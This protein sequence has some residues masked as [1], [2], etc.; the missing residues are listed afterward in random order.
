MSMRRRWRESSRARSSTN[1]AA[2]AP[3]TPI[4]N[5]ICAA[6]ARVYVRGSRG[7]Y[8]LGRSKLLK[9][10]R[11]RRRN[12]ISTVKQPQ[13]RMG[14][15]KR[16]PINTAREVMGIAALHPSYEI[17]NTTSRSRGA[18]RPEF[19]GTW[20]FEKQRAR[21]RPG[22]RCTRGLACMMHKE[23]RT[24]AYRF[25]GEHSGLPHAKWLYGYT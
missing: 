13:C 17:S 7:S 12:P 14:G 11:P 20:P 25:S 22:A 6:A 4:A 9:P 1:Q 3:S 19:A 8:D 21:G 15:A 24:R 16:I 18:R 10:A 2:S 23:V 5:R